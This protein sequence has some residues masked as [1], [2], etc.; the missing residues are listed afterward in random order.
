MTIL[1]DVHRCG[2]QNIR[3][4]GLAINEDHAQVSELFVD[5]CGAC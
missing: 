5:Q 1:D 3:R 4:R 2:G